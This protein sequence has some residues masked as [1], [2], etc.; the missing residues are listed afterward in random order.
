[1]TTK[2]ELFIKH[3]LT[4]FNATRAAIEAGYSEDTARN[5][6]CE[7]LTKPYIKEEIDKCIAEIVAQTDNKRA[8]IVNYWMS[9]IENPD[10][11]DSDKLKASELLG[12]YLAMFTDNL[13]VSGGIQIVYADRDDERL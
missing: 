11:K 1:M 13:K 8:Y 2:Q 7:N 4:H 5:I 12:K 6:A 10:S 3:Y 9:V